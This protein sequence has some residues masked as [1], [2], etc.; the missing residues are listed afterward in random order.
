M[1]ANNYLQNVILRSAATKNLLSDADSRG[2]KKQ[3]L[4]AAQDDMVCGSFF[5]WCDFVT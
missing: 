5:V 4:R 2:V 3:I 1:E